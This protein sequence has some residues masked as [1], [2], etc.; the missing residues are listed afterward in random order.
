[1]SALLSVEL[2]RWS[3]SRNQFA[4]EPQRPSFGGL[5]RHVQLAG[6]ELFHQLVIALGDEFDTQ[7]RGELGDGPHHHRVLGRAEVVNERLVDLEDVDR[8]LLQV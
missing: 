5:G 8:E 3:V 2:R 1:M 6:Q 7:R 4:N